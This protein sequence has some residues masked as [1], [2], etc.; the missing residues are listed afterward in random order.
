MTISK[1]TS[2]GKAR[3]AAMSPDGRY[4]AYV[5]QDQD[6]QSLWVRQLATGSSV[7]IIPTRA[8]FFDAPSFTPDGNY[9]YYT[10]STDHSVN[11]L[12][13]Y[14]IPTLGGTQRKLPN[15][16]MGGISFSPDG[17]KMAYLSF[18]ISRAECKLMVA[19]SDGNNERVVAKRT[20]EKGFRGKPSW[21]SDGRIVV[22]PALALSPSAISSLMFISVDDGKIVSSIDSDKLISEV[23]WL[24]DKSAVLVRGV[25][26]ANFGLAQLWY[27]P[28]PKGQS[29]RFTRDL[30]NYVSGPSLSSDSKSLVV[31]QEEETYSTF[32]SPVSSPD[33][34]KPIPTDTTESILASLGNGKL[35][36]TTDE[37]HLYS[38]NPDG[39]QRT[40]VLDK[41]LGMSVCGNEQTVVYEA[42]KEGKLNIWAADMGG[43]NKR[44]VTD[45]RIEESVDC[46]PDGKWITYQSIADNGGI[47]IWKASLDKSSPPVQLSNGSS[48][49]GPK[50]SPDGKQ[51]AYWLEAGIS[52]G[53]ARQLVVINA[54]DGKEVV[55]E[56]LEAAFA[57]WT[58]RAAYAFYFGLH[59]QLRLLTRRE[60]DIHHA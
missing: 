39:S 47:S 12:A 17:K 45:G 41:G 38:R 43:G 33:S 14:A 31:V 44:R 51:I 6:G 20:F 28:Y 1:L 32:V 40:D 5:Q 46:S 26:A 30:N 7:Q 9:I 11:T 54:E 24:S 42:L 48:G 58:S 8:V 25:E 19:D 4:A 60:A 21:S 53:Q 2:S 35:L 50:F 56:S 27:Q 57:E 22:V 37:G 3:L 36:T 29:Q 18:D 52:G 59:Q 10:Y 55:R 49:Y 16:P 15:V 13:L 23:A 34:Q